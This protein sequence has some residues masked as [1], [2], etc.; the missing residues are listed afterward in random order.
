MKQTGPSTNKAASYLDF[1]SSFSC[2]FSWLSHIKVFRRA[3]L[4]FSIKGY[5]IVVVL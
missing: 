1:K 5:V 2:F 4:E 3:H